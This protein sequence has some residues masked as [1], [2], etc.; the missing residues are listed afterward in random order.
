MAK[1]DGAQWFDSDA[2]WRYVGRWSGLVARELIEWLAMPEGADWLDVGCGPGPLAGAILERAAPRRVR[3]VDLSP[4]FV[5][6]ARERITDERAS[7]AV[8]DAMDLGGEPDA[9]Y[10]AVVSG[11]VLNFLPDPQ[12]GVRA[13]QRVVKPGGVVAAYVW[14][15]AEGM[16]IMRAFWDAAVDLFPEAAQY[17]EGSRFS[18]CNPE[19]LS[20]LWED[21]GLAGVQTRA[22][23]APAV[24]RDFDDYW[25]P[26]LSEQAPAPRFAMS[27][28]PA[29]REALRKAVAARLPFH[30]DGS[31]HLTVRAWAVRGARP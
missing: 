22:I 16:Q 26:F 24:F 19:G 28:T 14:D 31:I 3:G 8:D 12:V 27:L 5:A 17:D 13:M 18:L 6:A 1:P 25:S 30:T 15:Y 2:C 10:D 29:D 11:L 7:F 21:A 23:D 4:Q 9:A 20:R